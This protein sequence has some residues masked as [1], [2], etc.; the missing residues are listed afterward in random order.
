MLA[1]GLAA[2]V[3]V[4][5]LLLG[6]EQATEILLG[7]DLPR[8][9]SE[10]KRPSEKASRKFHVLLSDNGFASRAPAQAGLSPFIETRSS[11]HSAR[12]R[13]CSGVGPGAAPRPIP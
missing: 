8:R 7:R 10:H 1:I 2:A 9:D 11:W 4:L 3:E 13:G 5:A 6:K 12:R